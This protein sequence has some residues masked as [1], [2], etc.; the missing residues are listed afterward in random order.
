[1]VA[2]VLV[3]VFAAALWAPSLSR[4]VA[5]IVTDLRVTGTF[6]EDKNTFGWTVTLCRH[7]QDAIIVSADFSWVYQDG[8]AVVP[9]VG[10]RSIRPG[11]STVIGGN[12]HVLQPQCDPPI[13]FHFTTEAPLNA[14]GG[15]R[16]R[17]TATYRP[18][19]GRAWWTETYPLGYIRVPDRPP[20]NHTEQQFIQRQLEFFQ[21]QLRELRGR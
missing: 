14:R 6:W 7:R 8:R 5:P 13:F 12:F 20:I 3:A 17:A 15:D 18:L 2:L 16:I 1:M 19:W 11:T 4:G 9:L 10:V 21:P